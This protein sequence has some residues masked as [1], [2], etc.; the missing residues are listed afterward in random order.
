MIKKNASEKAVSFR[1]AGFMSC[2]RLQPEVDVLS[3][4]ASAEIKKDAPG[5]IKL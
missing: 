1:L 2:L 3:E 5:S 4:P